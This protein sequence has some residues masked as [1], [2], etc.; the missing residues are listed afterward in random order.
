M[1]YALPLVLPGVPAGGVCAGIDWAT[2]DHVACVVDMTERVTS[3][4]SQRLESL[5]LVAGGVAH[6]FNNQLVSVV[7][8]ASTLQPSPPTKSAPSA[9]RR[10]SRRKASPLAP[11]PATKTTSGFCCLR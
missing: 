11:V 9:W 3:T 2:A 1:Q 7:S 5:G 8:D 10:A 6:E 4:Q